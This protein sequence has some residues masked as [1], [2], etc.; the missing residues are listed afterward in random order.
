MSKQNK[1]IFWVIGIVV[2]VALIINSQAPKEPG[3]V[4]LNVHYY[5]DGVEVFPTKGFL[6]FSIVTPPGGSFDQIS[7]D[8][9]G[10]ATGV[11]FSN[12]RITDASPTA[13]KNALP[14]TT[15][16]L[17]IGQSKKLWTSGLMN[18]VQFETMA[19]PV[20]F[21]VDVSAV[22]DYT[23]ET[24]SRWGYVDL[25][26]EEECI[27]HDSYSCYNNDV[28]WYDSCGVREEKKLPDCG[29]SGYTGV[30]YCYLNDVYRDYVT[31]GCSGSSCTSSTSKIK[32]DECG[33]VGCSGGVCNQP[34]GTYTGIH[35]DTAGSGATHPEGIT[36][37]GNYIWI[38]NDVDIGTEEIYKYSMSGSYISKEIDKRAIGIAT[39]GDYI[40]MVH[41]SYYYALVNYYMDLTVH[42]EGMYLGYGNSM[43]FGLAVYGNNLWTTDISD[44]AVYKWNILGDAY[45]VDASNPTNPSWSTIVDGNY[46]PKGITT[47]GN[48]IWV[49]DSYKA[50]VYKFT[51][52]GSYTG[53]HWDT[54][55]SGN[56]R[57]F[58]IEIDG[59][60]FL[61][62]DYDDAEIYKYYK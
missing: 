5:K 15:Q 3:M 35:W 61:I 53:I 38:V 57:P 2:L 37:D 17:L 8:I 1:T 23:K 54:A 13:F 24:L 22:N 32:Q 39:D 43:P 27:S 41:G 40:W 4:G 59:N 12:I 11:P 21:R 50:E 18:T 29:T 62:T 42:R 20:R 10:T 33:A 6:G 55:G 16:S 44:W 58:G 25:R 49:T 7:L 31:R 51:M 9:S 30:N 56:S 46:N 36:T 28:Y 48:Y 47:D 26:I 52:D 34:E 45:N 19:Q 60:Y 14:S